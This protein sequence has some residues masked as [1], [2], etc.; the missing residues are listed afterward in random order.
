M[1]HVWDE[2]ECREIDS[3]TQMFRF[4][5]SPISGI[6][7]Q[8]VWKLVIRNTP[9]Q[10]IIH[11]NVVPPFDLLLLYTQN[12]CEMLLNSVIAL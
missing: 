3:C 4:L 8:M 12:L 11:L 9:S 10:L 2:H 1:C 7:S 6:P 5:G